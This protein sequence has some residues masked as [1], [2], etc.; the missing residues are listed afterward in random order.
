MIRHIVALRFR[1]GTS[2]ETRSALYADLKALG[3]HIGGILDFRSFDN[4]SVELP[5]VRGFNDMFWFDFR[6]VAVRDAYL[7]DPVHQAIGSRIVA[8][9][10]GGAEGVF[11]CDVV[12]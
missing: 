1:K 5:L 10:E 12:L 8:E 9:L 4:V 3:G 2:L 6:D 11:V 7:A